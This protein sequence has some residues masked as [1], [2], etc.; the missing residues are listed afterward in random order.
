MTPKRERQDDVVALRMATKEIHLSPNQAF[1][2]TPKGWEVWVERPYM[3]RLRRIQKMA[4]L[5]VIR[6]SKN[7]GQYEDKGGTDQKS[8]QAVSRR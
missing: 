8:V 4:V 5:Q 6:A 2:V 7:R 1:Y 3:R